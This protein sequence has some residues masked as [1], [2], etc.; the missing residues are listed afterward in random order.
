LRNKEKDAAQ[1]TANKQRIMEESFRL[2]AEHGIVSVTMTQ[3]GEAGAV[4]RSSVFRY[5]PAKLD[6]VLAIAT[7]KWEEYIVEYRSTLPETERER[8]TGA[9]LLKWYMDAFLDLYRN[10]K[11]ILRFNYDLNSYLRGERGVVQQPLT[12]VINDLGK[13]FHKIYLKGIQDGTLRKDISEESI[14]SSSFHIM[15]AA[16]TRYAMGLVYL[17]E[18]GSDS[19]S[20]LIMLKEMLLTRY[21]VEP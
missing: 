18:K 19:E 4:D 5:Y 14:F 13:G 21:V 7:K 15:L 6:L 11:D 9:D 16:A 12:K 1:M 3:I 10:H 17:P 20:E 8:M 2:F